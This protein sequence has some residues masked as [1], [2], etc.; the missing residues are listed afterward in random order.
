MQDMCPN[1]SGEYHLHTGE[2]DTQHTIWRNGR[3]QQGF[4]I[5]KP[6]DSWVPGSLQVHL[7]THTKVKRLLQITCRLSFFIQVVPRRSPLTA[8]I[9]YSMKKLTL[10]WSKWKIAN[11]CLARHATPLGATSPW[12]AWEQ[13]NTGASNNAIVDHLLLLYSAS[14]CVAQHIFCF[15]L[16]QRQHD[17]QYISP[18]LF[19]DS[20]IAQICC[21]INNRLFE[22]VLKSHLC[23]RD[24]STMGE[25]IDCQRLK[26][27]YSEFIPIKAPN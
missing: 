15:D 27:K 5:Y 3:A 1:E 6:K 12:R 25:E 18:L 4:R 19:S 22:M 9:S 20:S 26:P 11:K 21:V 24:E 7:Q 16:G 17:C 13:E 2:D 14:C 8:G 10:N 23:F